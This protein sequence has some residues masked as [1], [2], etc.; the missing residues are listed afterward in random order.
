MITC[1]FY[2]PSRK[3]LQYNVILLDHLTT[4][5]IGWLDIGLFVRKDGVKFLMQITRSYY[6]ISVLHVSSMYKPSNG[7]FCQGWVRMTYCSVFFQIPSL[8]LSR[9]YKGKCVLSVASLIIGL[10]RNLFLSTLTSLFLSLWQGE[11]YDGRKAD[12]WS[13][14]VILFALLVVSESFLCQRLHFVS[15]NFA[16]M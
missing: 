13:C 5:C 10:P 11:K 1:L 7:C 2:T 16:V 14:G 3:L 9:G 15:H 4:A 8:R 6:W 12:V